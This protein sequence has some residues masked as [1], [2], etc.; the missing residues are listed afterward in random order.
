MLWAQ[1]EKLL[2]FEWRSVHFDMTTDQRSRSVKAK[3]DLSENIANHFFFGN[4]CIS[5]FP[6]LCGSR[7]CLPY[8]CTTQLKVNWAY[9]SFNMRAITSSTQGNSLRKMV[10]PLYR[11][12]RDGKRSLLECYVRAL[13]TTIKTWK[14]FLT[15]SLTKLLFVLNARLNFLNLLVMLKHSIPL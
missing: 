2:S 6:S 15:D 9:V 13:K 10:Q 3:F 14:Y 4:S 12:W 7:F 1:I 5:L 11:T 8:G